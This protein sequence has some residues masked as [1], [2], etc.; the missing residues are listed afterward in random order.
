MLVNVT[1]TQLEC[2]RASTC[3]QRLSRRDANLKPCTD[4]HVRDPQ[5]VGLFLQPARPGCCYRALQ[6][7][8]S[9][10][11]V[12][13]QH[14]SPTPQTK[15]WWMR[16]QIRSIKR[17]MAYARFFPAPLLVV[18]QLLGVG[19]PFFLRLICRLVM[20]SGDKRQAETRSDVRCISHLWSWVFSLCRHF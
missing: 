10:P 4:L 5:T 3:L 7:P 19:F 13:P 1:V 20:T 6:K 14:K 12:I 17:D 11:A 15:C 18:E 8:P 2:N 16:Q 9:W